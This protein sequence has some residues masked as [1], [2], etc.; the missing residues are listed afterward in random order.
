MLSFVVTTW[1]MGRN[2]DP[3]AYTIQLYYLLYQS[4]TIPPMPTAN[5]TMANTTTNK[6]EVAYQ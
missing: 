5:T 6:T 2:E 4:D 1:P 3:Y